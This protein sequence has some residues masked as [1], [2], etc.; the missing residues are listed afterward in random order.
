[1]L[2][3]QFHTTETWKLVEKTTPW[4]KNSAVPSKA[5][6]ERAKT[7]ERY[8]CANRNSDVFN[9]LQ[10]AAPPLPPASVADVRAPPASGNR[11]RPSAPTSAGPASSA[12][13]QPS[14]SAG[15]AKPVQP[16]AAVPAL[17]PSS[18]A[19]APPSAARDAP[20]PLRS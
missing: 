6:A 19:A 16:P 13:I 5:P 2:R 11:T 14:P 15:S 3:P 18:P 17:P 9:H 4:V 12:P 20:A 1:M 8:R 10:R 7:I